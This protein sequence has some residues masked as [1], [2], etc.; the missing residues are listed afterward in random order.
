MQPR[1]GGSSWKGLE[2]RVGQEGHEAGGSTPPKSDQVHKPGRMG[3]LP[4]GAWSE[5]F[6]FLPP[7]DPI[8]NPGRW[9]WRVLSTY[10][11][12]CRALWQL[13]VGREP[14]KHKVL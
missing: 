1:V 13:L 10:T 9:G 4:G 12:H 11:Q 14:W 6:P 2:C 8:N 5:G 7:L 3:A